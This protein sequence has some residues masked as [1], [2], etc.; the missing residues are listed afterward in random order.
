MSS[1]TDVHSSPATSSPPPLS[2]PTKSRLSI[3]RMH[4]SQTMQPPLERFTES[5]IGLRLIRKQCITPS[6]RSFKLIEKGCSRR[7]R[8]VRDVGMP[9]YRGVA[10]CEE[11][12]E[13]SAPGFAVP[14]DDVDFWEAFW[15]TGGG[16]DSKKLAYDNVSVL[17]RE[18]SRRVA[19]G[20]TYPFIYE[21]KCFRFLSALLLL[22][23]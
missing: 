8:F 10:P 19:R 7:L 20:G 16:M 23:Q 11:G 21:T 1:Q 5:I 2:L 13:F 17:R 14:V 3:P 22:R 12:I 9:R 18:K 15:V 6:F 4:S